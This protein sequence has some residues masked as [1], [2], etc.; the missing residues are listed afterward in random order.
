[1]ATLNNASR[2]NIFLYHTI[3]ILHAVIINRIKLIEETTFLIHTEMTSVR[4]SAK[5]KK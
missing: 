4:F 1:M 5:D 3:K 2:A